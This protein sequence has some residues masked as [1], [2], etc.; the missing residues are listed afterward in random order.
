MALETNAD[1][2][3]VAVSCVSCVSVSELDLDSDDVSDCVV[4]LGLVVMLESV[5]VQDYNPSYY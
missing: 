5:Q 2:Y 4:D 1:W 3:M